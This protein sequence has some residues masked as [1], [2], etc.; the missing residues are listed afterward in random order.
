MTEGT[1]PFGY[2]SHAKSLNDHARKVNTPEEEFI[3]F[4]MLLP[5]P[6]RLSEFE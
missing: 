1:F 6:M 3:W 2:E 5:V 4:I